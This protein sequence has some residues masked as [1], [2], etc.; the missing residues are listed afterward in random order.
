MINTHIL[1]VSGEQKAIEYLKEK[2]YLIL[3]KNYQCSI[4]E[5][6]IICKKNNVIVFVEVKQRETLKFGHPREAVTPYKI[7]KI[8]M[9]ATNYLKFNKL[10]NQ[11]IRFDVIDILADKITHIENCF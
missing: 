6:D 3:N 8:K 2:G 11:K 7:N 4:G 1:G 9:V 10:T 5:I